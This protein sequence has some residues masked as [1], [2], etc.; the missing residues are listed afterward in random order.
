M[1]IRAIEVMML[2]VPTIRP[3][4]MAFATVDALE[5]ALVRVVSDEGVVGLGEAATIAPAAWSA[6]SAESVKRTIDG[7]LAP[8]LL[9]EDARRF[10]FLVERMNRAAVGNL[11]A[12]SAVESALIDLVSRSLGVPAAQILGGVY[13]DRIPCAWTLATGD[14]ARDVDEAQAVLEA[15]RFSMFKIKVGA[16]ALATDVDRVVTI[17]SRLPDSIPLIVDANQAWDGTT[18]ARACRMLDEAGVDIIEQPVASW[19]LDALSRLTRETRASIMADESLSTT[20]SALDL[21][22]AGAVSAFSLKPNKS[23]GLFA[24]RKIAGLAEAAGVPCYGG[25]MLESAVG[26]A[27][28]LHLYATLPNLRLGCELLCPWLLQENITRQTLRYEDGCVVLPEG[29]GFGLDLDDEQVA[30]FRR[31][32]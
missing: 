4:K 2:D 30:R 18:A 8:A 26:T 21:I 29:P 16:E 13:R 27:A 1:K 7:S 31:E 32:G 23:G 28:A 10:S 11:F 25:S 17:K 22:R 12:K 24:T 9:G 6:E 3:A 19:N 14:V 5:F 20:H 15:G